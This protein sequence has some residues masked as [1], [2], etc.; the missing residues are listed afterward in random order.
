MGNPVMFFEIAGKDGESLQD[1]YSSLYDEWIILPFKWSTSHYPNDILVIDPT[2]EPLPD[3]GIRGHIYPLPD[4]TDFENRI[5]IFIQVE[6]LHETLNKI[7][8]S[9]GKTLV[10]PQELPDGLGAIAMFSD[11]S[12]NVI[13]LHQK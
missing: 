4:N 10:T 3:Q 7:E 5:S 13:G 6:D 12:G 11:P 2:P 1:F 8:N 9:G